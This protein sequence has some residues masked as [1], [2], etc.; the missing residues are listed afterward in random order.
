MNGQK[1]IN[2]AG[3]SPAAITNDLPS[4]VCWVSQ[5]ASS[6]ISHFSCLAKKSNQKK[7]PPVCR[8]CGVPSISRKQAGLR[9]STWRGA[10]PRAPLRDSNITSDLAEVFFQPSR[11]ASCFI[12]ARLNLCFLAADRGGAQGN[13][14]QT[15]RCLSEIDSL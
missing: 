7:S 1:Q 3:G 11:M 13:E 9:N 4:V 10:H 14:K 5:M 6:S 12:S 15:P 2:F 8:P